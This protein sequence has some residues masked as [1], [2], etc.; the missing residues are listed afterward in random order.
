[1]TQQ[2]SL[3]DKLCRWLQPLAAAST[4][5]EVVDSGAGHVNP[6]VQALQ[7]VVRDGMQRARRA[8][9]SG[10]TSNLLPDACPLELTVVGDC[11]CCWV[12]D[13]PRRCWAGL[14]LSMRLPMILLP[15]DLAPCMMPQWLVCL[16]GCGRP[17]SASTQRHT[18]HL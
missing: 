15:C 8:A 2:H 5:A 3:T 1:M 12:M 13:E 14:L 11:S 18:Q 4:A 10:R 16:L 9:R 6:L 17:L 7:A